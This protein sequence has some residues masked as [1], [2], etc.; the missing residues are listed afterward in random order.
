MADVGFT[1]LTP[2]VLMSIDRKGKGL[3]EKTGLTILATQDLFHLLTISGY[4]KSR[5]SHK[6]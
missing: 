3:P 6:F 2:L 4:V 1:R 5:L